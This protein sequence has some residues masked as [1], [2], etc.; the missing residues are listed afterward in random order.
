MAHQS[1]PA[2]MP[3][4]TTLAKQTLPD[5]KKILCTLGE[6][7]EMLGVSLNHFRGLVATGSIETVR[8]GKR[9][10]RAR[11][12]SVHQVAKNGI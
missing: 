2:L 6:G 10:I 5:G 4:P 1:N 11:I 3:M 12:S 8:V 9:A 7:A